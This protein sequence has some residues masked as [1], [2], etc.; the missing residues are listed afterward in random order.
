[1][2]GDSIGDCKKELDMNTCLI[3][4]AY[5]DRRVWIWRAL[6]F[7]SLLSVVFVGLNEER[8]LQRKVD[9]RDQLLARIL[10]AAA[11]I[12]KSEDQ[13]RR[14]TRD[15]LTRVAKCTEDDGGIFEHLLWTVTNLS[16]EH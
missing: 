1:L 2:G 5:P 9:T 4:N 16:F 14:I 11:G 15:P 7:P 8:N 13:L 6:F 12:K 10:N 3:L